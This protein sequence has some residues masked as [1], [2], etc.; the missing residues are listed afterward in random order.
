V[1][2]QPEHRDHC[3]QG[4]NVLWSKTSAEMPVLKGDPPEHRPQRTARKRRFTAKGRK[5]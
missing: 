3:R 1:G 5:P 4:M 2:S